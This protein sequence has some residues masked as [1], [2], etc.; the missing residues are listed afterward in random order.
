MPMVRPAAKPI[1][2]RPWVSSTAWAG[3]VKASDGWK[4]VKEARITAPTE[5]IITAHIPIVIAPM[6]STLRHSSSTTRASTATPTTSPWRVVIPGHRYARYCT[7]PCTPVDM[8][9][10]MKSIAVQTN[11]NGISRPVRYW[12]A[13]RR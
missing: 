7:R 5:T 1:Q 8:I 10:G 3:Q 6:S 11:R 12:K 9:S 2:N 4:S 13:S